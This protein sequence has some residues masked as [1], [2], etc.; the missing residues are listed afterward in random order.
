MRILVVDDD[1]IASEMLSELLLHHGHQPTVAH[2][3]EEALEL[4]RVE[5]FPLVISDWTMPR[6]SGDELCR[7]IRHADWG[8]YVTFIMLTSYADRAATIQSFASGVDDYM[9]KPFD[10]DEVMARLRVAERIVELQGQDVTIFALA[11]LAESR[12][13]DTGHHLE[14]VQIYSRMLAAEMLTI[15]DWPEVDHAFVRRIHQTSPLHDIGKVG[16][17]DSILRKPGKLTPQ[18]FDVMKSHTL[19]GAETL[20]A[21]AK[22]RSHVG[23]LKMAHDIALAHHEKW[24]GSG[25]PHGLSGTDIPLAARITA[26]ADVYDALTTSRPYK[27]A[28][29]HAKARQIIVESAGTHFDPDLVAVFV[30]LEAHFARVRD[31]LS[32]PIALAA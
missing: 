18:E 1:M 16:I 4:M 13:T 17:P 8:M 21:A 5:P 6:M 31:E 29:P 32:E 14:R 30:K 24:D 7:A 15:G 27:E 20:A 26:V 28:F 2:S 9:T 12:D 3:A 19:R 10:P 22:Q 11:K 25:Y 23:Y